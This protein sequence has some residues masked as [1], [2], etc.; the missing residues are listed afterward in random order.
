M[1]AETV[2]SARA[3]AREEMSNMSKLSNLPANPCQTSI[4]LAHRM[5]N[6][7]VNMSNMTL[8]LAYAN[9]LILSNLLI[10][11]LMA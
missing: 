11:L 7:G 1:S 9:L 4:Q 2:R 5:S 10:N 8:R 3:C 6:M